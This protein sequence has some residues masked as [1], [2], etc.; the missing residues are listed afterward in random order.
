MYLAWRLWNGCMHIIIAEAKALPGR[1]DQLEEVFATML[2]PSRAEPG[3]ISYRFF[4]SY[5]DSDSVLFYEE[6]EDMD[7][8]K[9][10]FATEHFVGLGPQ[11]EGLLDGEPQI[12]V[13]EASEVA[14]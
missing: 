8:V 3:C 6:Y 12:Q 2:E 10:H 1:I 4:R 5:D 13:F 9:Y 14:A 11:V 7:A